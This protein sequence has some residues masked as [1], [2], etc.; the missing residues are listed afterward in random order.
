MTP[1]KDRIEKTV[2]LAAS[3]SRVWRAVTDS[4]EFGQWF[5]VEMEGPF[6]AGE[7]VSGQIKYPGYEHLSMH[8]M[9]DVIEPETRFSFRWYP[10]P[11]EPD[12]LEG[13][14]TT[15]VEFLFE[16][17]GEGTLLRVIESG[18]EALPPA[19]RDSSFRENEK[20]WREQIRNIERY[21]DG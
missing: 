21:V 9:V 15:T 18:F 5:R 8:V 3:R 2:R 14:P 19:L 17:A 1:S 7:T 6:V 13:A 11:Q 20:G 4:G 16:E 12:D 10:G